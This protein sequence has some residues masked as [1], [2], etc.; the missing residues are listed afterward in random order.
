MG[1]IQPPPQ[2][3]AQ[4]GEY[5]G[6]L[7][8]Y[9]QRYREEGAD[10]DL[11]N[12]AACLY[13]LNHHK[14]A[15][16]FAQKADLAHSGTC[17]AAKLVIGNIHCD[18]GELREA[19]GRYLSLTHTNL[20]LSGYEGIAAVLLK[21]G[22]LRRSIDF[23]K[24]V[25]QRFPESDRP[26]LLLSR[27]YFELKD[28]KSSW[29]SVRQCLAVNNSSI[30]AWKMAYRCADELKEYDTRLAIA[31]KLVELD[32][33]DPLNHE[34]L[35]QAFF[36]LNQPA[37]YS[38]AYE[39][40]LRL[41]PRNL[42]Y[43]LN[44]RIAFARVPATAACVREL[45]H[46]M[47]R[48]IAAVKSSFTTHPDW[49]ADASCGLMPFAFF[50]AYSDNN[51]ASVYGPYYELMTHSLAGVIENANAGGN[52]MLDLAAQQQRGKA[53][54]AT[55][56][57]S[58]VS[59]RSRKV[60]IGMLSRYFS[61]HSNSQAFMGLIQNLDRDAF[62]LVLIHRHGYKVDSTHMNL[63][64]LADEVAYLDASLVYSAYL[65]SSLQLDL[66][67]FTDIGMDPYD[68]I[69]PELRRCPIQLTGWGLPHTTG[70]KSIDYYLSS[71]NLESPAHQSEYTER[72][73][74]LDGLPCCYPSS[75][76]Y[77]RRQS[78]DYFLLPEGR[79]II[80]CIQNFWKIHPD[81]DLILEQIAQL[82]PEA[83]FVFVETSLPSA[84]N[85]YAERL[86]A[87]APRA[88]ANTLFLSRTYT[89]DFLSLCDCIDILL[90]TPYYGGGVTSYMS[91][92]VGTP[93]V[94]WQGK[95][96]RD[97]T[98]AGIYEYL[99]ISNAPIAKDN[100][101]YIDTVVALSRDSDARIKIKRETVEKAHTLYDNYE[102][103]RSFESFCL[104]LA[105]QHTDAQLAPP[106]VS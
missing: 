63:N 36:E 2:T 9:I 89:K 61:A 90:D 72:L 59:N 15:L 62:E 96:L 103:V 33:S 50:C 95:R 48:E 16:A 94:C 98:T 1:S 92:Y 35:G 28:Y 41:D 30:E 34:Y 55:S 3:L 82:L 43:R 38:Q 27:H 7:R 21:R 74:L 106:P 51:L 18:Q 65:L 47:A 14:A 45:E 75:E 22:R 105:S 13:K 54:T 78:R 25:S 64:R 42:I 8:L 26:Y 58:S 23:L 4:A 99:D 32:S 56:Q 66:L 11:A 93:I 104:Q 73:A 100:A 70:L 97:R 83:V 67:F 20:A 53:A 5:R 68:F 79:L 88:S 85:A 71:S 19:M 77:Y 17:N 10:S 37:E 80:G 101:Q 87:R 102:F 76:I 52:Q 81:F 91:M 57:P 60:R 69:L 31:K 29:A 12:I 6:A 84:N 49:K 44:A 39:A 86:R 46:T 40:A 24:L